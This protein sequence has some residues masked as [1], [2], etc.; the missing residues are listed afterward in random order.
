MGTRGVHLLGIRL[1]GC[2]DGQMEKAAMRVATST[3]SPRS[4]QA[5]AASPIVA[6]LLEMN[7][8]AS[9][10]ASAKCGGRAG[11]GTHSRSPSRHSAVMASAVRSP[12]PIAPHIGTGTDRPP[13]MA[14]T[15]TSS[16]PGSTP[17]PPAAIWLTRTTS[18]PR[19][20]SAAIS[21][22]PPPA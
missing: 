21:G 8:S 4:A 13:L 16:T 18:I 17:D 6:A 1:G 11:R 22:P 2:R 5:S 15:S 10:D 14:S 19:L 7:A 3:S 20:S 12:V 9:R